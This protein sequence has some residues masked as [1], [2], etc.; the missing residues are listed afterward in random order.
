MTVGD[1]CRSRDAILR[2]DNEEEGR[3]C[4]I[5]AEV[6]PARWRSPDV[7]EYKVALLTLPVTAF[8]RASDLT[9]FTDHAREPARTT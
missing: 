9:P 5:V 8:R 7:P 3:L 6:P 1:V 4:R 2:T